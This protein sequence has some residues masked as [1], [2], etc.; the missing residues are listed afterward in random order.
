MS[1]ALTKGFQISED[2]S[3]DRRALPS[4][5]DLSRYPLAPLAPG[6]GTEARFMSREVG[7]FAKAGPRFNLLAPVPG[8]LAWL[9]G[10]YSL[11]AAGEPDAAI[12]IL[13]EHIDDMLLAGDFIDCDAALRA[14]DLKRFDTNLL[15]ALLSITLSA[16]D[17]LPERSR[18][19]TK[20][21]NRLAQSAPERAK[22]LLSG[23][24]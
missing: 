16:A 21:E 20:I 24:R 10:I 9:E 19:V 7:S 23:L 14:I 11:V 12:D 1:V 18:L 22:R 2:W 5:S 15:I 3:A 13:F 4:A 17:K 8:E 6:V